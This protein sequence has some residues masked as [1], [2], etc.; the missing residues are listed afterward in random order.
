MNEKQAVHYQTGANKLQ[1]ATFNYA[2]AIAW[3]DGILYFQKSSLTEEVISRLERW[4]GVKIV[5]SGKPAQPKAISGRFDNESLENVLQ[6]ISFPGGFN[7]NID[8]K[9]V[10]INF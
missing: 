7:Y 1:N 6:S 4:Y 8:G 10:I 3:K 2:E 9:N 5:V